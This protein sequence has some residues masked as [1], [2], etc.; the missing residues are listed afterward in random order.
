MKTLM[1]AAAAAM[2]VAAI[3]ALASAQVAPDYYGSLG[4]DNTKT[5]GANLGAIQGRVGAKL[6]P[7]FGVE[8]EVAVG[9]KGDTTTLGGVPAKVELQH[10][11]AAYAVGFL[12]ITSQIDLIA[13]AGY[14][15]TRAKASAA[16]ASL[17]DSQESWN[18]GVG[19]QYH[20]DDKNGVRADWTKSEYQHGDANSDTVAVAYV[21]RF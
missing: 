8:G 18:Y 20:F 21:R 12:P 10:Q 16:G 3:P 17:A 7:N 11:A 6:T 2:S 1:L 4:Y 15:T 14:G 19:A 13:R 9:V 5:D